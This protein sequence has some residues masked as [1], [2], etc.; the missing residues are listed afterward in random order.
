MELWV[1]AEFSGDIDNEMRIA[2]NFVV[3]KINESISTR[4]YDLDLDSWD[5]IAIIM[6]EDDYEEVIKYSKKKREIDF[7]LKI[8]HQEF[9]NSSPIKQQT[10][11]YRLILRTL[12]LLVEKGLSKDGI[13]QLRSDTNIVAENNGWV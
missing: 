4:N 6:E 12:D 3:D 1:G 8:N 13:N 2:R 5:C 10:L 9:S 7:R 11:F